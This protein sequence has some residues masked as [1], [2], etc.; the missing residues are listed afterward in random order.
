[1]NKLTWTW[2]A[3]QLTTA[4]DFGTPT[5]TTAYHFCVYDQ[6][7]GTPTLV[8]SMTA[9]PGGRCNGK[10]CWKAT[11]AGFQFKDKLLSNTGLAGVKL[12]GNAGQGKAVVQVKGKGTTLPLP[13]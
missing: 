5:T 13:A 6:T 1:A 8:M 10:P 2:K 11:S 3:G 9:P 4:A 12:K 7:A